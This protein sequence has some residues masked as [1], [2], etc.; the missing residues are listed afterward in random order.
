MWMLAGW[1]AAAE[2]R[3]FLPS[4]CAQ[5]V[6]LATLNSATHLC[7]LE[8][9]PDACVI[10]VMPV[11][12]TCLRASFVIPHNAV[13]QPSKRK[14]PLPQ[15][16][17]ITQQDRTCTRRTKAVGTM[18][19]LI[20]QMALSAVK[21]Q[22]E[23]TVFSHLLNEFIFSLVNGTKAEWKGYGWDDSRGELLCRA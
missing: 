17:L 5:S 23:G 18:S 7:C 6:A 13:V 15:F 9:S 8:K 22:P 20:F 14:G 16:H 4:I 2:A 10:H 1:G 12:P 11:I 19:K 21:L 3:H